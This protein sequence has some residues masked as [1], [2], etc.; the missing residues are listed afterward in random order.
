[1]SRASGRSCAPGKDNIA[2]PLKPI[3]SATVRG[4]R[5]SIIRK[6]G[7]AAPV[8]ARCLNKSPYICR[9]VAAPRNA[10]AMR[11]DHDDRRCLLQTAPRHRTPVK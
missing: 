8:A 10:R 3:G 11:V 7:G 9:S 1:M 6:Q 2:A 4:S 5:L